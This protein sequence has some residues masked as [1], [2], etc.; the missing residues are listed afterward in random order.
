MT[1][2]AHAIIAGDWTAAL[3]LDARIGVVHQPLYTDRDWQEAAQ[4]YADGGDPT[5]LEHMLHREDG[6][7]VFQSIGGTADDDFD[8]W[9]AANDLSRFRKVAA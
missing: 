1:P 2:F 7:Q 8:A 9:L 3:A 5:D 6:W 4:A